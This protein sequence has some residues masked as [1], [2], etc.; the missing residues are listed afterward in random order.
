M[1]LLRNPFQN[2]TGVYASQVRT[3]YFMWSELEE[4]MGWKRTDNTFDLKDMEMTL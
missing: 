1:S 3:G 4:C 2:F